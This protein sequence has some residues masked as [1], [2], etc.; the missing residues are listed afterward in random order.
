MSTQLD[1]VKEALFGDEG[2]RASNFKMHP[3]HN[4]DVSVEEVAAELNASLQRVANGEYT[5][6]ADIGA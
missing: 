3:G 6:L 2:L 1:T 5:V 4:R